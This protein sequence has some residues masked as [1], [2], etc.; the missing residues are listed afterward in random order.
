MTADRLIEIIGPPALALLV[1]ALAAT[2]ALAA[3]RRTMAE[4]CIACAEPLIDGQ[5]VYFDASGGIIHAA[6]C[7]PERESYTGSDGEPLKDGE[8]IPT[9]WRWTTPRPGDWHRPFDH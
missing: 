2:L 5:E 8:P 3:L 4:R 6:C 1:I 9:P 7:G